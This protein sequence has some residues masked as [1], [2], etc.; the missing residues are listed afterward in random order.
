MWLAPHRSHVDPPVCLV[1]IEEHPI[2]SSPQLPD[3]RHSFE[4]RYQ[5]PQLLDV[6]RRLARFIGELALNVIQYSPPL[7]ASKLLQISHDTSRKAD[8]VHIYMIAY[9]LTASKLAFD[10][11]A[12]EAWSH[13]RNFVSFPSLSVLDALH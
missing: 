9:A 8:L 4:G 13:D 2:V 1:N 10:N 6:L 7:A 5:L 12:T 3:R 11:G